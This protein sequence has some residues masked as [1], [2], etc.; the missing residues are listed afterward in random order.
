MENSLVHKGVANARGDPENV[1]KI[2]V[3]TKL[4]FMLNKIEITFKCN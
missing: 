3:W 4:I 1:L 2:S